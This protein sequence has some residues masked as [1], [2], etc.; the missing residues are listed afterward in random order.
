MLLLVAIAGCSE[1]ADSTSQDNADAVLPGS[2]AVSNPNNPTSSGT[3]EAADTNNSGGASNAA[4]PAVAPS[5]TPKKLY[6]MNAVYSFV[7][8]NKEAASSKVVL[9]TFD[10]GPK[11][12]KTLGSLLD[13]LDKHKAKAIFFVNGYRVKQHP[14]LLQK[15]ADRG[16]TIGNHSWDHIDL[17]KEKMETVKKQIGDV[18]T[19]VNKVTGHKP[20]FFRPP[21]GSGNDQVKGF[22]RDSG[23]LYMT[24]SDGSLDWDS[25]TKNKPDKVVANV[26]E[27]LHPGVNIL[28]H[29][30]PWTTQA[31]DSLLTKLEA[32]GYGFIDPATIDL[33]LHPTAAS[34]K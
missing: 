7:P 17:K 8:I 18:Q 10:D 5:K 30:L 34:A 31:L 23:M 11:A 26:L 24:W 9:L 22:V 20:V 4:A 29:E 1:A 27:Q 12:D 28:M 19:I 2:G 16:Q 21:F 13:T 3:A 33:G 15:I 32:K 14:E 6:R 25:S